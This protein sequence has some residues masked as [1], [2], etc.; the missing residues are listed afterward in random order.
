MTLSIFH[1]PDCLMHETSD[2]PERAERLSVSLRRLENL[3]NTQLPLNAVSWQVASAITDEALQR[4][5]PAS[6]T[7]MLQAFCASG[8][9]R[10]DEDTVASAGSE[11]AARLSAG[12]AIDAV[13]AVLKDQAES[14]L[15]LCRPPGHHALPDRSMG[16]CFYNNAALAVRH[17]QAI[18]GITK[19][20]V[21]DWDLHHGNGTEAIFYNDP[22]VLFVSTHQDPNWPGTGALNDI[23]TQGGLGTTVNLPM[24]IGSGDQSYMTVFQNVIAPAVA[25]F[26]PELLIVSAGYDAH[27]ADPLGRL[28]LSVAGFGTLT[29]EVRALARQLCE[30][31]LVLVL[32]GGYDLSALSWGLTATAAALVGAQVAD[33]LGKSP[34]PEPTAAVDQL[35]QA[36]RER[37]QL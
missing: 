36:A 16:F 18:A 14:A 24:P 19:V 8:G 1:H 29:R 34:Y 4:V 5:H 37:H 20:A 28:G 33:P 3:T 21:I 6:Y 35:I 10:L 17:A 12:C 13:N 9:G 27:W 31:R 26:Q 30:G 11:H 23:G 25:R 15:A 22:D 2:H 32:E 7:A